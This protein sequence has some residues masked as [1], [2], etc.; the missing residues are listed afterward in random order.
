MFKQDH[1]VDTDQSCKAI[2]NHCQAGT[3]GDTFS[4]KSPKGCPKKF[5]A[6]LVSKFLTEGN[7]LRIFFG[8]GFFAYSWKLPAYNGAFLLTVDNFSFF[9]Y[10]L[11][12]FAYGFS[13]FTCSWSFLAYSGKASKKAS[14]IFFVL[15]R[16][17]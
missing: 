2:S 7:V 6:T 11:S 3:N 16:F 17:L 8:C 4:I 10:N 13:F 5:V 15:R 12:F 9:T 1:V 14:P